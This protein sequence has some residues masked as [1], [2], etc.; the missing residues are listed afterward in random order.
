MNQTLL[1]L[2]KCQTL[3]YYGLSI[4]L[5]KGLSLIML[6][7]IAGYLSPA[8]MGRLELLT[9]AA[10]FASLFVAMG[11]EDCLFRFAGMASG[12]KQRTVVASLYGW[13][14]AIGAVALIIG[15]IAAPY[16]SALF[17]HSLSSLHL[18]MVWAGV[19]LE[20]AISIPLG[21]LRMRDKALNFFSIVIGRTFLQATLTVI[22]LW[23][24]PTITSVLLASLIA[25]C[26]Q[27]LILGIG[28]HAATGIATKK[29]ELKAIVHYGLPL[30]GSGLCLFAL[31]G[32][33]RVV[34]AHFTNLSQLGIYG[35]AAKFALATILLMQ[36][37]GMWWRPRRFDWLQ[38]RPLQCHAML[39]R[40]AVLLCGITC[41]VICTGPLLIAALMPTGY[42]NAALYVG[43]IALMLAMREAGE[44]YNMGLLTHKN[45]LPL[46]KINII[47]A[48]IGA[49]ACVFGTAYWGL[50]G[51][52]LAMLGTQ[53]LRFL[54][55]YTGSQKQLHANYSLRPHLSRALISYAFIAIFT[56]TL[57]HQ[58]LVLT[59]GGYSAAL[60][61]GL[62]SAAGFA[63]AMVA[64]YRGLW[65]A[66]W[67]SYTQQQASFLKR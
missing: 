8:D 24:S 43:A 19:A 28:Q 1:L 44:I 3:V 2:K 14:L 47:T 22:F 25:T 63:I 38:Q 20:G 41:V 53:T 23:H 18:Q 31:N 27:A 46:L 12:N 65:G 4:V 26:S 17:N 67:V 49:T 30:L 33:D 6:P 48:I 5:M 56:A 60:H 37:F 57:S 34:I 59:T 54:F 39:E 61:L 9:T 40:G 64:W 66:R 7:L 13:G 29:A 32:I 10:I 50:M 45:T 21:F 15:H 52:V 58:L 55:I 42:A 36:P 35:V 62:V 16:V 11:L 51:C